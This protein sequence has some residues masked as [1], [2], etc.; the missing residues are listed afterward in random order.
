LFYSWVYSLSNKQF[1]DTGQKKLLVVLNQ[2][3]GICLELSQALQCVPVVPATQQAETGGL[4]E[5]KSS[6]VAW[7]T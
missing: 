6:K 2:W 4:I 5:L 1:Q 3:L 7:V